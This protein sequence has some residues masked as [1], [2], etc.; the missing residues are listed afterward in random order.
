MESA[1]TTDESFTID[2]VLDA[3]AAVDGPMPLEA[4]R[5]AA[6]H[7][8]AAGPALLRLLEDAAGGAEISER[9]DAI[10]MFAI[11]LMGQRR[12]QRAYGPICA[13]GCDGDRMDQ[14]L[15]DGLTEDFSAIL[16]R[17]F[18]GD[19]TPL[20]RLIEAEDA[21]E[22]ARNAAMEALTWLT[23]K[24]RIDRAETASY[25]RG[26]HATLRPRDDCHIWFGWQQAVA[27]LGL[28]GLTPLVKEAFRCGWINRLVTTFSYFQKDLRDASRGGDLADMFARTLTDESMLDDLA[29]HMADW[30][31]NEAEPEDEDPVLPPPPVEGEPIRNPFRHVG[32]NDPCPCGSGKKFKKCCLGKAEAS[33][34]YR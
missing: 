28:D 25:L 20:R 5:W 7:W 2:A 1:M 6:A 30:T 4:L 26:L 18:N 34:A 32:R 22:F 14:V 3:F 19:P 29:A 12:D 15:G 27:A 21:D 33:L 13:I 16:V 31:R 24:G 17:I 8:D 11:Y 9:T 23:L 10:L